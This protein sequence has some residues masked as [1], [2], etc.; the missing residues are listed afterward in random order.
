MDKI[1]L[2]PHFD[3]V[4]LSCGGMVAMATAAGERVLMVT[5]CGGVP[6]LEASSSLTQKIHRARGFADGRAYVLARREEDRA[7]AAVLAADVEWGDSLDAIYRNPTHY[8]RSAALLGE[9]ASGDALVSETSLL[10][11][12]LRSR[13]PRATLYAPL[14]AGGH[15]DHRG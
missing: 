7:A 4:A 8:S 1:F 6:P 15:V 12:R 5:V 2:S 10:I 11:A 14:G 9:P 13:F 3:D